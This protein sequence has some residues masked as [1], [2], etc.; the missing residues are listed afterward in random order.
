MKRYW[1]QGEEIWKERKILV[2]SFYQLV[3]ICSAKHLLQL[4]SADNLQIFSTDH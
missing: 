4:H 1:L 2:F 3:K